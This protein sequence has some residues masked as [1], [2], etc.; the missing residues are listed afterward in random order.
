MGNNR[1]RENSLE[2]CLLRA[3][4]RVFVNTHKEQR[5]RRT[6]VDS[7]EIFHLQKISPV[8]HGLPTNRA[9]KF[10]STQV[11]WVSH[12]SRERWTCW[13]PARCHRR[14]RRQFDLHFRST[15]LCSKLKQSPFVFARGSKNNPALCIIGGSSRRVAG[16]RG[17]ENIWVSLDPRMRRQF[18]W[19]CLTL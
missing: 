11:W 15:P 7:K 19:R 10:T 17:G 4:P 16:E 8:P 18:S 2:L 5:E 13:C 6:L 12:L 3:P 9:R 1:Y 14:G